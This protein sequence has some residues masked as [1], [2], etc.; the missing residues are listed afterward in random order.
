MRPFYDAA[1]CLLD[2]ISVLIDRSIPILLIVIEHVRQLL[3]AS[4]PKEKNKKMKT[5][6]IGTTLAR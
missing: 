6:I 3:S 4:K 2:S 1:P 5:M